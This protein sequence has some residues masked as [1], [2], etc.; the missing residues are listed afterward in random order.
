MTTQNQILEV[1]AKL[2]EL[3]AKSLDELKNR[4]PIYVKHPSIDYFARIDSPSKSIDIQAYNP[5]MQ[6]HDFSSASTVGYAWSEFISGRW[7]EITP[8]EFEAA[9]T[10]AINKLSNL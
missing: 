1:Q 9:R 2:K 4:L 6:Y 3:E 8:E 10:E 7:V 5:S